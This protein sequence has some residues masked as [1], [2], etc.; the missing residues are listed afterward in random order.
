MAGGRPTDYEGEY[1][2]MLIEHM[3]KGF[4]FESF[5][6]LLGVCRATVYNWLD[7]FPEFLD[8]KKI[9]TEKCRMFWEQQGITGLY[10][11]TEFDAETGIKTTK[12]INPA[13][14][15]FNMKNRF[16]E[17]WSD[18]SKQELTGKDGGP[19]GVKFEG[20]DEA[21]LNS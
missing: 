17:D 19:L 10:E 4:S 8:A 9:A 5:A 14:Y 12:K 1:C 6:G 16:K 7:L 13:M 11:T 20:M 2:E 18:T 15:I 3:G 21:G